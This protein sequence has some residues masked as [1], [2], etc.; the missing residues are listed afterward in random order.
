MPLVVVDRVF[1]EPQVFDELQAKEEAFGWC[2][3]ENDVAF[4]RTFFAVD[5]RRMICIYEAPDAEA[6]RR[7]QVKAGL[8]FERAW[9]ASSVHDVA[10][11]ERPA[12]AGRTIVVVERRFAEPTSL[13][14]LVGM[15]E[16]GQWC[17]EANGLDLIESYFSKDGM[18]TACIYAA[19]DA[20]SVRKS[21][22]T[23]ELPFE[24]AWSASVHGRAMP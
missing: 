12:A 20:E 15:L 10:G 8:P 7:T 19:I 5:R 24:R 17:F 18:C 9:A 6:V 14:A 3:E 11:L 21:N 2:L 22:R 13:D 1:D 4:V 23:V 16:L